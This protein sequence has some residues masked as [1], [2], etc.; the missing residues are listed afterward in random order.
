M[1]IAHN[2]LHSYPFVLKICTEYNSGTA[3]L[4]EQLPTDLTI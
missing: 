1:A 2:L 3:V 4:C